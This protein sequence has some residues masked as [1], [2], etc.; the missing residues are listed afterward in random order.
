MYLGSERDS[1]SEQK[2]EPRSLTSQAPVL[3]RPPPPSPPYLASWHKQGLCRTPNPNHFRGALC[4]RPGAA[5]SSQ[6]VCG[7]WVVLAP[8]DPCGFGVQECGQALHEVLERSRVVGSLEN[9]CLQLDWLSRST[10]SSLT[11]VPFLSSPRQHW[12]RT[13][14]TI[15]ASDSPGQ[16]LLHLFRRQLYLLN[17]R[18]SLVAQMV[19]NL[20]AMRETWVWF[21][22][23]EDPL[24]KEMTTHSSILAWE[25]L[26]TEEPG[27][28]QPVGSQEVEHDWAHMHC[29]ATFFFFP[30]LDWPLF[31]LGRPDAWKRSFPLNRQGSQVSGCP[32]VTAHDCWA[33][34]PRLFPQLRPPTSTKTNLI[35]ELTVW[36]QRKHGRV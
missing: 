9:R 20:P 31:M 24:E 2:L 10:Q 33:W 30:S 28:L 21:L 22:G 13:S 4:R 29:T 6:V 32:D 17:L 16:F 19:K 11:M 35:D 23:W 15:I 25:I 1:G 36:P 8:W 14:V 27:G 3:C 12:L 7:P 18:A 34:D 26:W 5:G